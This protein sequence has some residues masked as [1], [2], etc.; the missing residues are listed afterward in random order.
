MVSVV[1]DL[2]CRDPKHDHPLW[3][4]PAGF[5]DECDVFSHFQKH[6]YRCS[7]YA[8]EESGK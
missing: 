6:D 1:S 4:D 3:P 8:K 7:R 2:R 5:C